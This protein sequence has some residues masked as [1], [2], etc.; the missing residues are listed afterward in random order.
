[1][2]HPIV[3]VGA[4]VAGLIAARHLE[5]A[6]YEPLVLEG[7]DRPGGRVKTDRADGYLFDQGFQVLLT[8]YREAN[9][10]LDMKALGLRKFEPGALIFSGGKRFGIKDP[11]RDPSALPGMITS[12]VGSLRDKWLVYKLNHD[13]K[14][15]KPEII[16]G[17]HQEDTID[18][19][20]HY[21]FSERIIDQFFRPFFGGIFLENELTTSSSMFRFVFKMFSK[22]HAAI[23][24]NGMEAIPAQ[25]ASGLRKTNFRWNTWVE[26]VHGDA[27]H[28]RNGDPV[29][30]EK[31][32]IASDPYQM[33]R[34]LSNQE[35]AYNATLSLYF[36]SDRSLL[37]S[38]TIALVADKELLINN[39][40]QV[41]EVAPMYSGNNDHLI[42]VTLKDSV[43]DS[44]GLGEQVAA[45]LREL[46]GKP[47][48]KLEMLRK[49]AIPKALPVVD[50][51]RYDL[52]PTQF[53]IMEG[54][55]LAGDYML[56]ASLDAAMRSGRRAAEAV[57]SSGG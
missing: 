16:F 47:E 50:N 21:G 43:S 9:R 19:L 31:L 51:L 32:I 39:F 30:F 13:L 46:T 3:I 18:F 26:D 27:V 25:L 11:L 17:E 2:K 52:P 54:V 42:S 45:E 23:P 14:K 56:N 44:N 12:P 28:I 24:E 6:G 40:C 7:A 29:R 38:P 33:L 5:E 36:R 10:Y 4:G 41:T 55:Y 49:Y 22:G 1:M 37:G 20:R 57:I 8:A 35:L 48:A 15:T 34:G 53:K